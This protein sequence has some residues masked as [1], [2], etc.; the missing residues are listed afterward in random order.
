M[1]SQNISIATSTIFPRKQA[2]IEMR[3]LKTGFPLRT[4]P[5]EESPKDNVFDKNAALKPVSAYCTADRIRIVDLKK[6]ASNSDI[7]I[8]SVIYFGECLY[9][10]AKDDN[11]ITD[12]FVFDY[13]V[14]VLWGTAEALESKILKIVTKFEENRYPTKKIEK[15]W[16]RY[17][18][19]E[20]KP[21]VI[22][23]IIYLNS[24][25]FFNKMVIS[26]A[27][28]QSVKLD[29]FEELTDRTI[30]TVKNLPDEI[31]EKDSKSRT[32]K[33]VLK[34]LSILHKLRFNINLIS[35]ILD[36]PE[37]LWYHPQYSELYE[38]FRHYLGI[39]NRVELLNKRCDTI[40][41]LL[42]IISENINTRTSE[43]LEKIMI[44]L[45]FTSVVVGIINITLLFL[46]FR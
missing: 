7:F 4:V 42:S 38:A 2:R 32:R 29:F 9:L 30:D 31:E 21:V 11:E 10:S 44:G 26:S 33:E 27:I 39:K 20:D 25:D 19:V 3:T 37:I 24:D 17:G 1:A 18:I 12:I 23:D 40:H 35:N 8:H 36:D 5:I 41:D 16:F 14:T 46:K 34:L 22:N 45:T 28:A 13:G 43:R 15:E 6:F